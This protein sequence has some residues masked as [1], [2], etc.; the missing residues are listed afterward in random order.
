MAASEPTGTSQRDRVL[1][2]THQ[3]ARDQPAGSSG[4]ASMMSSNR[5][6]A[7]LVAGGTIRNRIARF[8]EYPVAEDRVGGI[9]RGVCVADR[10]GRE[11]ASFGLKHGEVITLL[12]RNRVSLKPIER[13]KLDVDPLIDS[14][15]NRIRTQLGEET[16]DAA[17]EQGLS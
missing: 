12:P 7:F 1:R 8:S 5:A 4:M 2:P 15:A 10:F 6:A 11:F 9:H 3:R 16:V 13:R 14:H 17:V